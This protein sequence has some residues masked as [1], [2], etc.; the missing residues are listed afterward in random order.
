[1]SLICGHDLEV[2]R[3]VTKFISHALLASRGVLAEMAVLE[4][5]CLYKLRLDIRHFS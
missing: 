4:D 3:D 5:I 1:M 2:L